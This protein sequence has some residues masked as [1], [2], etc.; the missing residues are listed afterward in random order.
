METHRRN[1]KE[2]NMSK[3]SWKPEGQR[4]VQEGK[5][6]WTTEHEMVF[7]DGLG[8]HSFSRMSRLDMLKNYLKALNLP[9]P[10]KKM[11]KAIIRTYVKDSIAMEEAHPTPKPRSRDSLQLILEEG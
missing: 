7:I 4:R 9:G 11:D 3:A 1:T 6:I 10:M 2:H 8:T 5:D